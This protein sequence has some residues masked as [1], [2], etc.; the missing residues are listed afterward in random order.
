MTCNWIRKSFMVLGLGMSHGI[1]PVWMM[2]P[3]HSPNCEWNMGRY[4]KYCRRNP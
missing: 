2:N 3:Q 1:S 4:C